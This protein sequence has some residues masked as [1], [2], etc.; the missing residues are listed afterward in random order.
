MCA[1][2]HRTY[3][4]KDVSVDHINPC[5]SLKCVDDVGPFVDA[6][7]CDIEGLQILCSSCHYI[8]SMRER[9]MTDEDIAAAQ[10]KRMKAGE[11]RKHLVGMGVEPGKNQED[12]VVQYLENL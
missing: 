5:G 9:G 4:K 10:F 6:L 7:F 8:K 3:G 11:Q 2:C 1:M 12:R